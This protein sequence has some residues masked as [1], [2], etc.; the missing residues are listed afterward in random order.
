MEY[1]INIITNRSPDIAVLCLGIILLWY[2]LKAIDNNIT[3]LYKLIDKQLKWCLT[4][5]QPKDS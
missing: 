2:K 4:Y 5:F 1:L 3:N